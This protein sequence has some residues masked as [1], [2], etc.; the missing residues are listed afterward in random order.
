METNAEKFGWN[1]RNEEIALM[2]IQF[3][4]RFLFTLTLLTL[5]GSI[6]SGE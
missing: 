6:L 4:I 1:L 2:A 5:Y 3:R